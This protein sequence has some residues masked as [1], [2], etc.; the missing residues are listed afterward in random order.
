VSND[1]PAC[2]ECLLAIQR[3]YADQPGL[4]LTVDQ[5]AVLLRV[6][7]DTCASAIRRAVHH[8]LLRCDANGQYSRRG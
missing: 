8:R 2:E 3:M 6:G 4:A 5:A 1:E 7:R